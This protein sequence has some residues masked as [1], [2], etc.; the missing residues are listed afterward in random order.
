MRSIT[1]A[2]FALFVACTKPN[3]N[4]CCNDEADCMAKGIPVG[5][6][7]EQGLVC[8]GNQCIA[9]PCSGSG[10]CD[11]AAPYCIE[12]LC[13]ETCAEDVQC[14]G[15]GQDATERFCVGQCSM[16]RDSMDCPLASPVCEG[17]ACRG[18][19]ADTDCASAACDRDSAE[20]IP[21]GSILYVT[22]NGSTSD[23][24]RRNPCSL[25]HAFT[26]VDSMRIAIKLGSG[27]HTVGN[28][29]VGSKT[30]TIYGPGIVVGDGIATDGATVRIRD[31][32]WNGGIGC[33]NSAP[34]LPSNTLDVRRTTMTDDY[35]II[36]ECDATF[37]ESTLRAALAPGQLLQIGYNGGASITIDRS[38]VEGGDPGINV[39]AFSSM[40]VTNSVFVNQ[41]TNGGWFTVE[42]NALGTSTVRF[43]TFY[44]GLLKCGNTAGT[45]FVT[46]SNN[47]YVNARGGAPADTATGTYCSH[48][49]DLIKPQSAAVPGPGNILNGEPKWYAPFSGDFHL[50]AGSSAIDTAD[51]NAAE[52]VD[53]DGVAR[54]QGTA[55][56]IGAFEYKP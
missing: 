35:T 21:E 25:A 10:E 26:L 40:H 50:Q 16:C 27:G 33:I 56:D 3:P 24:T 41:G 53:F 19:N 43:S 51:P 42:S 34:N 15:F 6:R 8:R 20:C 54:P 49:Y 28:G 36:D 13:A 55:R 31:V 4:R 32:T 39:S 17:G 44:N 29:L 38:V 1:I 11:A 18:C 14:P 47:I 9:Q 52:S 23:C 30:A 45:G 22:S 12:G 37:R 7:C 2:A 5:S 46:S 48:S